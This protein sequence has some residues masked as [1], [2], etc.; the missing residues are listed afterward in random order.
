MF[1][2]AYQLYQQI[3]S[4]YSQERVLYDR[5]FAFEAIDDLCRAIQDIEQSLSFEQLLSIPQV[6]LLQERLEELR[7][8]HSHRQSKPPVE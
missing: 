8:R 4:K 6:G 2:H 7:S 1:N 5:S 3:Q